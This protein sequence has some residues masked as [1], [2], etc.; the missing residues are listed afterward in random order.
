[1]HASK[2]KFSY[3]PV[4]HA[5]SSCAVRADSNA[6]CLVQL[7]RPCSIFWHGKVQD[8][9]RGGILHNFWIISQMA[10]RIHPR[11][12]PPWP[13]FAGKKLKLSESYREMCHVTGKF[14]KC[15]KFAQNFLIIREKTFSN[16][17]RIYRF[18]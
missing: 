14:G 6:I 13:K 12:I 16:F 18:L 15:W 8:A 10:D 3:W 5:L 1:M 9:T 7:R 2:R 11:Q 4:T 17:P